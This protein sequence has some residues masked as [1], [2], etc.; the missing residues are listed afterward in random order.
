MYI[1][2]LVANLINVIIM[3]VYHIEHRF[4]KRVSV[5][6]GPQSHRRVA[7]IRDPTFLDSAILNI[8]P[9]H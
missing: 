1:Y 2:T 4:L 5:L 3:R 6:L 7:F 8:V 9:N